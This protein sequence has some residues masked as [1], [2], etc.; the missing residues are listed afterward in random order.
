MNDPIDEIKTC[1][2]VNFH[3]KRIV[4]VATHTHF[5]FSPIEAHISCIQY[6]YIHAV[7][8]FLEPP[9]AAN[10]GICGQ[11]ALELDTLELR[12]ALFMYC[13]TGFTSMVRWQDFVAS[14]RR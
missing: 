5:D 8:H 2:I 9:S 13:L 1:C 6:I 7:V 14:W 11:L 3:K 10:H 4:I 12:V